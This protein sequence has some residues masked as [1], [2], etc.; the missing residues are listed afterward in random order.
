LRH[1]CEIN[2]R[3]LKQLIVPEANTRERRRDQH[4]S[5]L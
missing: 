1:V 4:A 5:G 2:P 3:L